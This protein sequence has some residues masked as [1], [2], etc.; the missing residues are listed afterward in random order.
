[1]YYLEQEIHKKKRILKKCSGNPQDGRK[2]KK[3]AKTRINRKQKIKWQNKD[4]I[5]NLLNVNGKNTP[6][7]GGAMMAA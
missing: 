4:N 3:E 1:M 7:R 6:T 5:K 2:Q